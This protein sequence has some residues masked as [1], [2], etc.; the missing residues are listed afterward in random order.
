MKQKHRLELEYFK[1]ELRQ[2]ENENKA[3]LK[4]EEE[5]RKNA[6]N[7]DSV[8]ISD[9]TNGRP[10]SQKDMAEILRSGVLDATVKNGD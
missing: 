1:W 3:R 10:W 5:E 6:A 4:R 2:K 7:A 8:N 9:T